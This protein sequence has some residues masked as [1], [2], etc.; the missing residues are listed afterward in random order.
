MKVLL[1]AVLLS[2]VQWFASGVP[3]LVLECS[4]PNIYQPSTVHTIHSL[5]IV[6]FTLPQLPSHAQSATM[7]LVHSKDE[8]ESVHMMGLVATTSSHKIAMIVVFVVPVHKPL[9]FNYC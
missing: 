4:G 6:K 3:V 5:G 8:S 7:Q 2:G 9:I 1:A